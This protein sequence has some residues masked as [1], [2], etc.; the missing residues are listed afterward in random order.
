MET[1]VTD[2]NEVQTLPE[3]YGS[4]ECDQDDV[5][6][7][8]NG[9][10]HCRWCGAIMPATHYECAVSGR[11][12]S[13]V[14]QALYCNLPIPT[15]ASGEID[16][17]KLRA[18]LKAVYDEPPVTVKERLLPEWFTEQQK[19]I[20]ETTTRDHVAHL[21]ARAK[22]LGIKWPRDWRA[23]GWKSEAKFLAEMESRI[24]DQSQNGHFSAPNSPVGQRGFLEPA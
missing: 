9:T 12:C 4:G 22:K 14:C 13:A 20:A 15:K 8:S 6:D 2:N 17:G 16:G 5:L 1:T 23:A 11:C 19:S 24:S 18:A 10:A 3:R 7:A 21:R